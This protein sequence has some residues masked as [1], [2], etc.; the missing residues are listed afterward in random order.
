[1]NDKTRRRSGR[2]RIGSRDRSVMVSKVLIGLDC[3]FKTKGYK[4][5]WRSLGESNPC[6]GFERAAERDVDPV[7]AYCYCRVAVHRN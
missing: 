6:F 7:A 1:M 5:K 3:L 2:S 4:R